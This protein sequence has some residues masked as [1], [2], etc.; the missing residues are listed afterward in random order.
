MGG[1]VLLCIVLLNLLGI[2][3][4][5]DINNIHWDVVALYAAA[6][7]MGYGL[8]ATGAALWLA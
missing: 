4:W 7:A 2:L 6:S 1:P 3:R 5:Q 8:A